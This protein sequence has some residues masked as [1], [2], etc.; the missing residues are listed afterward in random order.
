MGFSAFSIIF[1]LP[2]W[3]LVPTLILSTMGR[4]VLFRQRRIGLNNREFEVMKYRTML[5]KTLGCF[6]DN[7]RITRLG[8]LLRVSRI[9][10]FPQL[11]NILA[12]QMSFIGPRPLLPEYLPYYT[13]TELRRHEVSPG[14]SGLGQVAG[15]YM[16]WEDQ[17]QLDVYYVD[18]MSFHLD[19]IIFIR[20]VIKIFKP[21]KK[22]ITGNAGRVKFDVYRKTIILK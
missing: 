12:G 15:S 8:K 18:N 11:F 3:I 4:P 20:T 10:E 1:L 14:L 21:S 22:L 19:L 16:N 6:D 9:D 2:V 7:R 17:F 13:N 5:N